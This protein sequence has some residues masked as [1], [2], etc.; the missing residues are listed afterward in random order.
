M[1]R[2]D[3]LKCNYC[4]F[5]V[6]KTHLEMP[7]DTWED[8]NVQYHSNYQKNNRNVDDP[9]WHERLHNQ[10]EAIAR[11]YREKML[12][13]NKPL[14][15]YGCGFG[16][17]ADRLNQLGV[18]VH[19]YDRYVHGRGVHYLSESHLR[20]HKYGVVITTSV[21]EHVRSRESLDEMVKL[22]S[23]AGV[24]AVHTLV[25]ETV[26]CSSS[27]FYLLPVHCAFFTNKSMQILFDEWGFSSSIYHVKSRMWFWFK[28]NFAGMDVFVE[29]ENAKSRDRED[30]YFFK[31][32]FVDY[33]R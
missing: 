4:N 15:D 33:W 3:Y 29:E 21:F 8:L 9:R 23:P 17:L 10:A 19:K 16:Q 27:W 13:R 12:P 24:L 26:P 22:V 2:V 28:K 32:G 11:F 14:I 20:K 7:Q 31:R 5:V 6:S 30:L 25:K 1:T 18:R